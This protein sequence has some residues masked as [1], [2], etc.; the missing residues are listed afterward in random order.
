MPTRR[1]L[2]LALSVALAACGRTPSA[3]AVIGVSLPANDGPFYQDLERGM[4]QVN[5][6]LGFD[7]RVTT[8]D[9]ARQAS[10]VDSFVAH[11]VA[12]IVLAPADPSRIAGAI[13]RANRAHVPFFTIGVQAQ[14]GEVVTHIGSDERQGGEL[15]GW[16]V[17]QRLHGGGNV[18]I[19]DQP[20]VGNVRD[21]VAGFR[22]E[23]ANFPN[24][25]IVANPA[26]EP[27]TRAQ[28]ERATERLLAADQ[29]I[30]AIFGTTDESALGAVD[31]IEAA[32]RTDVIVV[33]HGGTPEARAAIAGGRRALVADVTPDPVTIGRSAIEITVSY[34]R[35]N[36]VVPFA[37]VRV[38]VI[39][40]DSLEQRADS[41]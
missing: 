31:A 19:L 13:E 17:S 2:P 9:A 5:E 35:G 12:A 24:I 23:L 33:G 28:A 15:A 10:V 36:R 22:S 25:R 30:D 7:L 29:R 4:R 11:A 21:R 14:G 20:T 27:A 34:V 40:R 16:Y 38:R 6:S 32:H 37:P 41:R 39:D 26:V 3:R 1:L 18:A 8:G